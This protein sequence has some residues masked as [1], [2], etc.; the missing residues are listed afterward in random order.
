MARIYPICSSSTGNCTFI[1]TK[2]HGILID[3]GCSFAALKSSLGLIGTEINHIEAIFITHEHIDHVKGLNVLAKH[4]KIPVFAS[5]GTI[6]SLMSNVKSPLP[7]GFR[8]YDIFQEG[9]RSAEFEVTPFH[10]PHDTPESV[11]YVI[12]YNDIKIGICTDIGTV[13]EEVQRNLL[14]CDAVLL[15]SNYDIDMLRRN[16]NYSPDLKRRISSASGH[17]SN[18]D[19]A[20]F[21]EKLVNSGTTRIVLGHLS[22]ENN[23]PNTAFNCTSSHL[24]RKGMKQ[25]SDFTLDVAPVVTEGQYI[26]L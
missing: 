9:Y 14:G 20:E 11:G 12:N 13:T 15:E 16:P 7:D 26:A 19:A 1:G 22:R 6:A 17:L 8:I 2:G 5:A 24:Q 25:G 23:T 4:S 10:T 18:N 3:D 21:A